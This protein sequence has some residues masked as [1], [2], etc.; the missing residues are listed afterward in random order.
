M[1]GLSGQVAVITGGGGG[2]GRD[3]ALALAGAGAATVLA[4]RRAERIDGT[5]GDI[6]E[7]GGTA[8]AVQ[9]DVTR[10]GDVGR[11]FARTMEDFGR[12]DILIN[13]AGTGS[14][15]KRFV[16]LSLEEWET[17]LATNLTGPFLCSRQAMGIMIAQGGGRIVN[18]GS[19]SAKTPRPN[20]ATYTTTKLGLE[21]LTRSLC[22]DGRAH[23]I[24]ASIIHL[25]ATDTLD[26]FGSERMHER[27]P[28][29]YRLRPA[30][31]AQVV[32]HMV[33][34]PAQANI[35]DITLMPVDQP[36]FIGRG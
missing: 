35:F 31:V 17:V 28:G 12:V 33:T 5:A 7:A 23:N 19:I 13:N 14:G 30:D 2:L 1:A 26:G 11:L 21:G 3:I 6:T 29:G 8:L 20:S 24:S 18:I 9:T 22:L 34:L 15:N 10:E 36:S 32:L 25:G 4:G 27:L 16:D